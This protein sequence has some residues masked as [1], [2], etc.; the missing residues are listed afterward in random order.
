M[1]RF[2][3]ILSKYLFK[4]FFFIEHR[5]HCKSLTRK[6]R[7]LEYVY[8]HSYVSSCSELTSA[9]V[10]DTSISNAIPLQ[11][12]DSVTE[13]TVTLRRRSG[14]CERNF[15]ACL[16]SQPMCAPRSVSRQLNG[17]LLL[18]VQQCRIECA[19]TI[20]VQPVSLQPAI[21]ECSGAF[22]FS[23]FSVII[24]DPDRANVRLARVY[25]RYASH[26]G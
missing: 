14:F 23:S 26:S 15:C 2:P 4:V 12:L 3:S 13:Q 5:L 9:F 6:C 8:C 21:R 18:G 20:F 10:R 25:A 24:A 17:Q 1:R 7:F 19:I 11:R 16:L 22:P